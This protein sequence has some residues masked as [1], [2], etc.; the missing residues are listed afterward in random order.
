MAVSAGFHSGFLMVPEKEFAIT[1]L[2]N[3]ESGTRLINQLFADDWVLKRFAGVRNLSVSPQ[4]LNASELTPYEGDYTIQFID[5]QG[6]T[7][8]VPVQVSRRDGGLE[9]I[10]SGS[11]AMLRFYNYDHVLVDGEETTSRFSARCQWA[12]HV[13]AAEQPPFVIGCLASTETRSAG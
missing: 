12:S 13:V 5:F 1:L 6:A 10:G 2:T 9:M 11:S 4:S 3:S 7:L 8:N